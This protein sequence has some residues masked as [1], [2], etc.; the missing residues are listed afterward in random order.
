MNDP[1]RNRR[2]V[3]AAISTILLTLGLL[4][5]SPA[6]ATAESRAAQ[7]ATGTASAD[8]LIFNPGSEKCLTIYN[9]YTFQQAP[10]VTWPCTGAAEQRWYIDRDRLVNVRTG[11][12]L[13]VYYGQVQDGALVTS[14]K[15]NSGNNQKVDGYW[16]EN[17]QRGERKVPFHLRRQPVRRHTQRHLG[18]FVTTGAKVVNSVINRLPDFPT[19]PGRCEAAPP[20]RSRPGSATA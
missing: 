12:C 2:A 20:R 4:A 7:I 16:R 17:N 10:V 14:F 9:G 15:C 8:F 1:R 3:M 5:P 13:D 19:W 11:S 18:L 6:G